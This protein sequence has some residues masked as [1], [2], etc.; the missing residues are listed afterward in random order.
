VAIYPVDSSN[1][2]SIRVNAV[3]ERLLP[4]RTT[5]VTRLN[6]RDVATVSATM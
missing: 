3:P 1:V 2:D 6:G 4:S 5:I